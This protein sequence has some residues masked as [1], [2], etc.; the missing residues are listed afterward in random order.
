MFFE[1]LKIFSETLNRIIR[2][3][4]VVFELLQDNKNE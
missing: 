2:I 3:N 1:R 4:V